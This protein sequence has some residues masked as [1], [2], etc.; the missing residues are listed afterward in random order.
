MSEASKSTASVCPNCGTVRSGAFCHRCGQNDK[1]YLRAVHRVASEML[2]ETFELDSRLL[3]TFWALVAKPGQLTRQFAQGRRARYMSPVRLYLITSL[4]FFFF[5]S[6]SGDWDPTIDGAHSQEEMA[7]A[8][9]ELRADPDFLAVYGRMDAGEKA[10][11]QAWFQLPDEAME[12]LNAGV[13]GVGQRADPEA[14][15]W[16]SR[17]ARR[18]MALEPKQ[19]RDNLLDGLPIAMFFL[20][21]VFALLMKL[22]YPRRYYTE[23]LVLGFHLH[24]FMFLLL[25]VLELLPEPGQDAMGALDVVWSGL[26]GV[27][28]TGGLVYAFLTL[29]VVY[30]QSL[31]MTTLKFFLQFIA[32]T[33]LLIVAIASAFVVPLMF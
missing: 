19:L 10:Q 16:G 25:T 15:S 3:R 18:A 28:L 26:R 5:L 8:W 7:E 29:K 9:E 1:D 24:S 12:E 6:M 21:P 32:Y 4:V 2:G 33:I 31:A 20:V 27:L 30:G 23:H 11:I 13:G 22:F 17:V 14:E